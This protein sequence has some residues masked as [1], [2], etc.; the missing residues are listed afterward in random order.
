MDDCG[1]EKKTYKE[2]GYHRQHLSLSPLSCLSFHTVKTLLRLCPANCIY[3]ECVLWVGMCAFFR[4]S[5]KVKGFF[6]NSDDFAHVV[7]F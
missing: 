1:F 6:L 5:F 7:S 4:A 3:S 2:G